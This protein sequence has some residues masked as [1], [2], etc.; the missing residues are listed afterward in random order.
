MEEIFDLKMILKN[1]TKINFFQQIILKRLGI[2][3]ESVQ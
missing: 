1:I 2:K 3:Y